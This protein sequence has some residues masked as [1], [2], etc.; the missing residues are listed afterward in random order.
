[1]DNPQPAHRADWSDD[2]IEQWVA[3]LLRGG[4][5]LAAGVTTL[6]GIAL[7]VQHGR[8]IADYRVFH[9]E[10]AG[11]VSLHGVLSGV[12]RLESH[13]VA[14]LGLM[15]LIATPV[16]RVLVSLVPIRRPASWATIAWWSTASLTGAANSASARST[17][18]T[19]APVRS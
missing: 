3:T 18:P 8:A 13:S 5:Y 14:Q 6:G 4:V 12:G 17:L 15:L 10:P 1:M 19:D 7:L 16:A 11:L 9:G 2:R